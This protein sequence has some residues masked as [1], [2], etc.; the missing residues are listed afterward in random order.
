MHRQPDEDLFEIF[1]NSFYGFGQYRSPLWFVGPYASLLTNDRAEIASRL[2]F[3]HRRGQ[4]QTVD[5]PRFLS[6]IGDDRWSAE[7]PPLHRVRSKLARI[8][9]AFEGQAIEER[10][11]SYQATEFGSFAGSIAALHVLA[12][13]TRSET[14]WPFSTAER[15]HLRSSNL[16]A[17]RFADRRLRH[18]SRRLRRHRPPVVIFYDLTHRAWWEHLAGCVFEKTPVRDCFAVRGGPTLY[19][20]VR[21]PE[22]IG[23]R[24]D[25]FD[26]VGHLAAELTADEDG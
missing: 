8:C 14:P 15:A 26:R 13:E 22:S 21:H 3:W 24:N 6:M 20:M 12:V 7:Q 4:P 16:Y 11:R 19:L 10:L 23:T 5:L 17:D 1:S 2:E 18:L 9:L 25:Y